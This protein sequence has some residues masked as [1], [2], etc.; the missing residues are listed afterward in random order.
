MP[1][2]PA[3]WHRGRGNRQE[4][5]Q[6]FQEVTKPPVSRNV[7]EKHAIEGESLVGENGAVFRRVSQVLRDTRNPVGIRVDHHL[8]LN[9]TV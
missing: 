7:L 3:L 4:V 9:T 1:S 5:R 8:R 2:P 6:R